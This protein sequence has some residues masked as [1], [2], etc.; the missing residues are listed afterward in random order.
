MLLDLI[1]GLNFKCYITICIKFKEIKY[2]AVIVFKNDTKC[3]L[4]NFFYFKFYSILIVMLHSVQVIT[5][6]VFFI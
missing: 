2:A 3:V 6:K 5:F 4:Y 1:E